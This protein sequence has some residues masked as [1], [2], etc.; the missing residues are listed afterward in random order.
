M[1][2]R[3]NILTILLIFS[4]I[5]IVSTKNPEKSKKKKSNTP[6][7]SG[8]NPF[9]PDRKGNIKY[10][11]NPFLSNSAIALDEVNNKSHKASKNHTANVA[12]NNKPHKASKNHTANVAVNNKSHKASKNHTA[13][14]AVNNKLRRASE[15]HTV[16]AAVFIRNIF[17][18][19]SFNMNDIPKEVQ[20]NSPY[21]NKNAKNDKISIAPSEINSYLDTDKTKSELKCEE[22]GRQF[23]DTTGVLPLV[24]QNSKII[25]V[26]TKKC[27]TV[28]RLVIGGINASPGDF[29]HMVALGV[30][31]TDGSFTF[32]CGGTLI[33]PEWVLT[34][35]HCTY[36]PKSPTDVRIGVHNLRDNAQGITTTIN[37]IMR[38][39]SYKP[40]AMYADIA[41]V[42]LNTVVVFNNEIR[43]A[44]LYEQYDT[45]PAQAWVTGWGVADSD[46]PEQSDQLQ[47]ASLDIIDHIAC[48][49]KYNKSMTV[50]YG[51]M[52]SMIC[53]GDSRGWKKDT[54]Q[55]DSGG[56]LQIPH[57]KNECLFQL[58]GITSF[59][60]GCAIP[61]TPGI[62][63]R[64][65]HYLNW[66]EDNVW[67]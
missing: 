20:T 60:L 58:L 27:E 26:N 51:I 30:K 19:S 36:G 40:P 21:I 29:P 22:Y 62:Y 41:L 57:P 31:T 23:L 8:N 32:S 47:K 66:I 5:L 48:A 46:I 14:V 33:A 10:E 2:L 56:P 16:N 53:A 34:A 17:L 4:I 12:V 52:P 67:P 35:A 1:I 63:T 38:H 6:S 11:R 3:L 25:T 37:K 65:S 54:C 18:Q 28:N 49:I 64:I 7:L 59:G 39:P 42:K 13:N 44:C 61:N 55:G 24:G 50:P 9:L 15:N 45:V 43:P